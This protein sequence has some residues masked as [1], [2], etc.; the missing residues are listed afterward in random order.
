MR[1]T[2][3]LCSWRSHEPSRSECDQQSISDRRAAM[4]DAAELEV[5]N[6]RL[7]QIAEEMG[8][9]LMRAAFS[10]NIKERRDYSCA[11]FDPS[12]ILIAQAAHIPVHLGS[13]ALSVRAAIPL[14]LGEGEIAIVNDPFAGGTHL[15]DVTL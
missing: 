13:T 9:A 5:W 1:S 8:A 7:A 2:V 3:N 6:H 14:G 15:P 4:T 11:L 12:G 10:P